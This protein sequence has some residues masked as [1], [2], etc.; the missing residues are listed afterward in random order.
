MNKENQMSVMKIIIE[1]GE[2]KKKILESIKLAREDE[3]GQAR[4]NSICGRTNNCNS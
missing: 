2:A 1:A 4:K 3:F